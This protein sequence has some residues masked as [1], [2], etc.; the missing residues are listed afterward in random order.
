M[1]KITENVISGIIAHA[2]RDAPVEACGYL[3]EKEGVIVH[4]Y[5]MKNAD[6]SNEH[7]SLDPEE[8]FK[9]LRD[10]QEKGFELAGVYHSHPASPA[11]PSQEDIKLAYDPDLSYVIISL[12]EKDNILKSFKIKENEVEPEEIE[13]V[14]QK[15]SGDHWSVLIKKG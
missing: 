3:A 14:E 15:K 9:A 4:Q 2:K 13:I 1:L 12:A 11:R 8:Q 6:A 5:K 7:F 10:M